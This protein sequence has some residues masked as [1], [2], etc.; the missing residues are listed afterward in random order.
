MAKAIE[1]Q[2]PR[3]HRKHERSKAKDREDKLDLQV[4][5]R[6]QKKHA[7]ARSA[8]V[9]P[10]EQHFRRVDPAQVEFL[11][12]KL[13]SNAFSDKSGAAGSYGE[14]AYR[15]LLHTRGKGFRQE[16]NKKKR[17]SYRGG[18]IDTSVHSIKFASSDDE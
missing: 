8:A 13:K 17:G 4:Q 15:D 2:R 5:P 6:R 1:K 3:K 7:D 12:E 18:A 10:L 11:D 16:K 9:E 14:K